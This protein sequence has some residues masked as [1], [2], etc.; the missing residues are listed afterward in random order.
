MRLLLWSSRARSLLLG[1]LLLWSMLRLTIE[2]TR[3]T[4]CRHRRGA[5]DSRLLGPGWAASDAAQL[6]FQL[7]DAEIVVSV[8]AAQCF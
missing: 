8:A 1:C 7:S 4:G 3:R 2:L 5:W 6:I